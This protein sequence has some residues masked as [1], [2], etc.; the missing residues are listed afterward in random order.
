MWPHTVGRKATPQNLSHS[1]PFLS[2][3]PA[4]HRRATVQQVQGR[5]LWGCHEG[6]GYCLPALPLPVH[7]R[8]PQVGPSSGWGG[9]A[10]VSWQYNTLGAYVS[11]EV[12]DLGSHPNLATKLSSAT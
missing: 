7:R 2:E 6:H 3:L 4:Q 1:F 11:K 12:G 8:L 10:W 9:Y 5:L